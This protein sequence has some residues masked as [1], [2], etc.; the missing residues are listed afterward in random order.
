VPTRKGPVGFRRN[1]RQT[2]SNRLSRITGQNIAAVFDAWSIPLSAEARKAC[3][4]YPRAAD[5]R[6]FEDV[7]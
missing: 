1:R 4:K 3:A 5:P 6:L 2:S 7:L